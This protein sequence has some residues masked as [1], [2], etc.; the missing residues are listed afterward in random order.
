MIDLLARGVTGEALSRAITADPG[1]PDVRTVLMSTSAASGAA[2]R[3]HAADLSRYL[4][5]P[6]RSRELRQVLARA[7]TRGDKVEAQTLTDSDPSR[8]ARPRFDGRGL[9]ILL[10][11]DNVTNQQVAQAILE[12]L[13]LNMEE[14]ATAG[15]IVVARGYLAGLRGAFDRLK[16][17]AGPDGNA[18]STG[19]IRVK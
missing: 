8:T 4:I 18:S 5:K 19:R 2:A 14:A 10:A 6:V 9:R 7:M 1:L 12:K 11:D 15:D 13:G 16:N 17:E 3:L